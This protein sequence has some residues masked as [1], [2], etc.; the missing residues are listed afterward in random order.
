MS[1]PPTQPD[2][3]GGGDSTG[4]G[5]KFTATDPDPMPVPDFPGDPYALP[6]PTIARV[7]AYLDQNR[8]GWMTPRQTRRLQ[9]KANRALVGAH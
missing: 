1:Y 8:G 6:T 4:P 7:L 2:N 5:R 9:H 3:P